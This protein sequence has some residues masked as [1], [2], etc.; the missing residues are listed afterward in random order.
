MFR[1][2]EREQQKKKAIQAKSLGA[3]GGG[4]G[5]LLKWTARRNT[6]LKGGTKGVSRQKTAQITKLWTAGVWWWGGTEKHLGKGALQVTGKEKSGLGR[7]YNRPERV[8]WLGRGGKRRGE[9]G[10]R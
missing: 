9:E 6:Q 1:E 10:V 5:I 7:L 2:E 8:F 4:G 3:D